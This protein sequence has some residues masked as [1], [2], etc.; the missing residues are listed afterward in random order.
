MEIFKD[1]QVVGTSFVD[2]PDTT[3]LYGNITYKDDGLYVKQTLATLVKEPNNPYDKN[4][5][6]VYILATNTDSFLFDTSNL[7][8][9]GN[10]IR[11][12]YIGKKDELYN[13]IN[14]NPKNVFQGLVS[15]VTYNNPNYNRK[16]TVSIAI[17]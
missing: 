5:I 12:G 4:A 14:N 9:K 2:I 17:N 3:L 13:I 10:Y 16:Y 11:I 7:N 1:I 6:A 8:V 15:I